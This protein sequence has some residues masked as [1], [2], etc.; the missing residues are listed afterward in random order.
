[1]ARRADNECLSSPSGHELRLRGLCSSRACEVGEL[2]DLVNADLGRLLAELAAARTK[3]GDQLLAVAAGRAWDCVAVGED[4]FLLPSQR[5]AAEPG[6][7]RLPAVTFD[8]CLAAPSR[9]VRCGDGGLV[10]AGHRRH[11]WAVPGG[12]GLERRGPHDPM[13]AAAVPDVTRQ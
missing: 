6:H 12:H 2:A 1:M 10:L 4:R 3:P 9:P 13:Q 11:R 8:S 5:Y 7:Q